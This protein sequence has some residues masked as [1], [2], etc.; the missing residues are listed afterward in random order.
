MAKNTKIEELNK[1][2]QFIISVALQEYASGISNNTI[3]DTENII[4]ETVSKIARIFDH[5]HYRNM[6]I[7]LTSKEIEE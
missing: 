7:T 2:D 6:Q 4:E 5:E 3:I 1:T